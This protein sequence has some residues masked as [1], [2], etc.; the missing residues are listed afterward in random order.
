MSR[1]R[2]SLIRF[3]SPDIFYRVLYGGM[4]ILSG[5]LVLTCH[6]AFEFEI[7]ASEVVLRGREYH[8][9]YFPMECAY[10]ILVEV[11]RSSR[12]RRCSSL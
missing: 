11:P 4:L 5:L 10:S 12:T 7:D 6:T 8:C 1:P 2:Q 3:H 9:I